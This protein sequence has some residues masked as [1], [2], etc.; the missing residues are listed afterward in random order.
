[1]EI[2]KILN[3][4]HFYKIESIQ[5]ISKDDLLLKDYKQIFDGLV[6]NMVI[7]NKSFED[8]LWFVYDPL[9]QLNLI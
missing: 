8:N 9:S 3:E 2:I 6:E 4:S 5:Q 7:K 1:M